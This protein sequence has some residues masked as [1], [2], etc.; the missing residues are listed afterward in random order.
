MKLPKIV[1][2][3]EKVRIPVYLPR[4]IEIPIAGD[5]VNEEFRASCDK[6]CGEIG[7]LARAAQTQSVS[8]C[9]LESVGV[10]AKQW[11][12]QIQEALTAG[13]K[14]QVSRLV[15]LWKAGKIQVRHEDSIASLSTGDDSDD[16]EDESE[17]VSHSVGRSVSDTRSSKRAE[18]FTKSLFD[19]STNQTSPKHKTSYTS[20]RGFFNSESRA[21]RSFAESSI[22][23]STHTGYRASCQPKI[24]RKSAA[25]RD[26]GGPVRESGDINISGIRGMRSNSVDMPTPMGEV[27]SFRASFAS[28]LTCEEENTE[29]TPARSPLQVSE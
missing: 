3:Y 13:E 14:T 21:T 4:F 12:C 23:D 22:S 27:L 19:K 11:E 10:E 17:V 20:M 7:Q 5:S 2:V 8:L 25:R 1:A 24:Y 28:Q 29:V 6:L 15:E 18:E 16:E 26:V 9:K